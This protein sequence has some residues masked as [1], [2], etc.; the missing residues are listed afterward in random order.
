MGCKTG[1]DHVVHGCKNKVGFFARMCS[2]RRKPRTCEALPK[3]AP[4]PKPEPPPAIL[5]GNCVPV[6]EDKVP[7]CSVVYDVGKCCDGLASGGS[8]DMDRILGSIFSNRAG[9]CPKFEHLLHSAMFDF[10][11]YAQNHKSD[12]DNNEEIRKALDNNS[13]N[14]AVLIGFDWQELFSNYVRVTLD[15]ID[16]YLDHDS[17]TLDKGRKAVEAHHLPMAYF[18]RYLVCKMHECEGIECCISNAWKLYLELVLVSV[19]AI[20]DKGNNPEAYLAATSSGLDHAL[21]FGKYLDSL[22]LV[23]V[24]PCGIHE[25]ALPAQSNGKL[26]LPECAT[27]M[28]PN[29]LPQG[30]M[31][32][33]GFQTL[34]TPSSNANPNS[35]FSTAPANANL[36]NQPR[37]NS[38]PPSTMIGLQM[39]SSG[40]KLER[41]KLLQIDLASGTPDYASQLKYSQPQTMFEEKSLRVHEITS[42]TLDQLNIVVHTLGPNSKA[43]DYDGSFMKNVPFRVGD[44]ELQQNMSGIGLT[45]ALNSFDKGVKMFPI[46]GK[47]SLI[48][49]LQFSISWLSRTE[50]PTSNQ[51]M[52]RTATFSV[53]MTIDSLTHPLESRL[54]MLEEMQQSGKQFFAQFK[55][56]STSAS[57]ELSGA[58]DDN[59]YFL[60]TVTILF[61][62]DV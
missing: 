26:L 20:K 21:K 37:S 30:G 23:P 47:A 27:P 6:C 41:K 45:A 46:N 50:N 22:K 10:I 12:R 14:Q 35:P 44:Y 25:S 55:I 28:M 15:A 58:Q 7:S 2:M 57:K 51:M 1:C 42:A 17:A 61:P 56:G 52:T 16:D 43:T 62:D 60:E 54:F 38:Q 36:Q 32:M 19:E 9:E 34:P 18:F 29:S 53:P 24:S 5:P 48:L 4:C 59:Y 40:E 31:P 33:N 11:L 39:G 13:H 49:D 8:Q 3:C